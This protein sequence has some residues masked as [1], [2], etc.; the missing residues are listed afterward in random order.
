M[1]MVQWY[2]INDDSELSKRTTIG[3]P[4]D[5]GYKLY[6]STRRE[7]VDI[8]IETIA[9][10]LLPMLLVFGLMATVIILL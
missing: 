4:T 3:K 5:S 2:D 8:A 6:Q 9:C 1:T 7:R 10:V